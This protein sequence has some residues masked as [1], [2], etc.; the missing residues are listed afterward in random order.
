M[1][2]NIK[3]S[4]KFSIPA[5]IFLTVFISWL[6]GLKEGFAPGLL[7][8]LF[9]GGV[10]ALIVA[11]IFS[12]SAKEGFAALRPDKGT[13]LQTGSKFKRLLPT[14]FIMLMGAILTRYTGKLY[15][16]LIA[17]IVSSMTITFL[18][19]IKAGNIKKQKQKGNC[20]RITS[21]SYFAGF[22]FDAFCLMSLINLWLE[23]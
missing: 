13:R 1:R 10:I 4:L 11:F 22:S 19:S 16:M 21:I 15:L 17:S 18:Q 3:Q 7:L 12:E 20:R 14:F 9:V 23:C 6:V 5:I 8:G 2:Q